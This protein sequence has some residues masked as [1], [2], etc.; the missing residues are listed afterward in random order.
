MWNKIVDFY[1]EHL[2]LLFRFI[3]LMY[4][5]WFLCKAVFHFFRWLRTEPRKKTDRQDIN[6]LFV[7]TIII[8]II[9]VG[10]VVGLECIINLIK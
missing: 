1:R 8:S 10:V 9:I 4:F 2:Q 5:V 3:G 7:I 6:F